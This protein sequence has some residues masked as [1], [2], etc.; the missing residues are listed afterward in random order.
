ME[1]NGV[2]GALFLLLT[3][4]AKHSSAKQQLEAD[5]SWVPVGWQAYIVIT[6]LLGPKDDNGKPALGFRGSYSTVTIFKIPPA[7]N[8][9]SEHQIP[10][11]E[12][13]NIYGYTQ[14][15]WRPYLNLLSV[16]LMNAK[17]LKSDDNMTHGHSCWYKS[18]TLYASLGS[19]LVDLIQIF[20]SKSYLFIWTE[21]LLCVKHCAP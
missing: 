1:L 12:W 15:L 16:E 6:I 7:D 19:S 17:T 20:S 11:V 5:W 4:R 14:R 21:R 9:C 18:H 8:F 10:V 2:L 13:F 3:F